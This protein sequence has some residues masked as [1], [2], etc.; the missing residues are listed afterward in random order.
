MQAPTTNPVNSFSTTAQK[1]TFEVIKVPRDALEAFRRSEPLFTE[2]LL[3]SGRVVVDNI[4]GG[5]E[6]G[7]NSQIA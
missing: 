5:H 7:T 3:E 6:H 4:A 1:P 2:F